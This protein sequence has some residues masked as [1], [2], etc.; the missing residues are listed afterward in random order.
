MDIFIDIETIPTQSKEEMEAIR[1]SVSPPANYKKPDTIAAWYEKEGE[2]AYQEAY[3]KTAL[4]GTTGE[5]LCIGFALDD[6]PPMV[7][8]RTLDQPEKQ[9]LEGFFAVLLPMIKQE[10]S[11][12]S[13]KLR[14]IGHN[15]VGFDLRYIWQRCVINNVKPS[16]PIPYKAK[17]WDDAIFD[18]LTEWTGLNKAGGSLD[19][20]SRAFGYEGKGEITGAN[21]WDY[22]L[23]GKEGEVAKYCKDDVNLTRQIYRRMNF[24]EQK[25]D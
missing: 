19:K 10:H 16:L 15:I 8:G 23:A 20:I 24:Q 13:K 4:S 7:V 2:N 25:N 11:G 21:V 6:M 1:A 17:P 14:W 22:V 18:T 9:V 3:R 12:Y 5:I